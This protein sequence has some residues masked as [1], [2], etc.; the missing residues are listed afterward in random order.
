[1]VVRLAI[2]YKGAQFTRYGIFSRKT[3][4]IQ[5]SFP[6]KDDKCYDKQGL[7]NLGNFGLTLGCLKLDSLRLDEHLHLQRVWRGYRWWRWFLFPDP[8]LRLVS[9]SSRSQ[10]QRR[11]SGSQADREF[12][13]PNY[14]RNPLVHGTETKEEYSQGIHKSNYRLK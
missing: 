13:W 10:F 3:I 1:M 5:K 4:K 9:S 14:H 7:N 12:S 8:T 11:Q 6:W 2:C